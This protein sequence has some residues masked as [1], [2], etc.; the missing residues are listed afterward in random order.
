MDW[1]PPTSQPL[2]PP[3]LCRSRPPPFPPPFPSPPPS[4]FDG[5]TADGVTAPGLRRAH[6]HP[7]PP[8]PQT[9]CRVPTLCTMITLA[10]CNYCLGSGGQTEA[11]CVRRRLWRKG[12]N[13][14]RDSLCRRP[15]PGFSRH[16]GH[17]VNICH[18]RVHTLTISLNYHN[19]VKELTRFG[20]IVWAAEHKLHTHAQS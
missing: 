10:Q 7:L 15:V 20:N 3:T 11:R 9:P 1:V 18:V 6:T 14:V 4:R 13:E 19:D 12:F 2:P 5:H 16:V 17:T 8:P